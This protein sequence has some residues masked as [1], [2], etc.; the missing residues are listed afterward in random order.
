MIAAIREFFNQYEQRF[1]DALAGKEDIDATTNSFAECF[2]EANPNGVMCGANNDEFRKN[3]PKGNAF[4]K[5]IGTK[6][7]KI[8]NIDITRLNDAHYM[9]KVYWHS[10]YERKD[11]TEVSIDFDVIY[12]L[13]YREQHLKIFAYITG[14]EQAELQKNGLI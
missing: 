14:D 7:M 8:E 3:I 2:I 12:L 9:A 1:N 5:N 10:E 11:N 6:L 4:Y 13:Q